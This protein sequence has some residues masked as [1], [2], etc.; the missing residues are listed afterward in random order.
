MSYASSG[1][2][3]PT[4]GAACL[5]ELGILSREEVAELEGIAYLSEHTFLEVLIYEGEGM[6]AYLR[7]IS[8]PECLRVKELVVRGCGERGSS[9]IRLTGLPEVTRIAFQGD[10]V[11]LIVPSEPPSRVREALRKAG[12]EGIRAIAYR[13]LPWG[14]GLEA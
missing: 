10:C 14:E 8:T 9:L 6:E 3:E 11:E 12:V 5:G 1:E 7:L 4:P 2:R 13:E